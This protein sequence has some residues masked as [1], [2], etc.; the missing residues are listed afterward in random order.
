[1]NWEDLVRLAENET[2]HT[3]KKLPPDL[4]SRAETVP[5]VFEPWVSA[6]LVDED[7]EPDV[8]GLFVGN[9]FDVTDSIDPMPPQIFLFLETPRGIDYREKGHRNNET[10]TGHGHEIFDLGILSAVSSQPLQQP[11]PLLDNLV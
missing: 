5:V 8:M 2:A 1:M 9:P 10:Y 6:E 7:I 11:D 3:L 4:G